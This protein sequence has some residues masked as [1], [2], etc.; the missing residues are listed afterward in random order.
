MACSCYIEWKNAKRI[1]L[2]H[3]SCA[4]E[5]RLRCWIPLLSDT[6][7]TV[8]NLLFPSC[9][10]TL[11]EVIEGN[12]WHN[13]YK[14][15]IKSI[16]GR[17]RAQKQPET[18]FPVRFLWGE[19]LFFWSVSLCRNEIECLRHS[20]VQ[21]SSWV[22]CCVGTNYNSHCKVQVDWTADYGF[23]QL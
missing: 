10:W 13:W 15:G 9:P 8:A 7:A 1:T 18:A 5:S 2:P 23:R 11:W 6:K 12:W 17:A 20:S 21:C 3:Q 14:L 4:P 16:H 19:G 22:L